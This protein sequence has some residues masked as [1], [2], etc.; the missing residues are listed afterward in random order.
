[1][2]RPSARPRC[3]LEYPWTCCEP[4]RENE[5]A[6]AAAA[7]CERRSQPEYG[8]KSR[9]FFLVFYVALEAFFRNVLRLRTAAVT[10]CK[11]AAAG[12]TGCDSGEEG[13]AAGQ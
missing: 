11:M 7:G 13:R 1:M 2:R 8:S 3:A 5:A 9:V 10:L 6:A 4:R 12:A